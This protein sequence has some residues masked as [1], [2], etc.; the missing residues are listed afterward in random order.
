MDYS[1]AWKLEAI[2]PAI[3]LYFQRICHVSTFRSD[4]S[5]FVNEKHAAVTQFRLIV[6]LI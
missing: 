1:F 4:D 2:Y 6:R 3:K 5:W